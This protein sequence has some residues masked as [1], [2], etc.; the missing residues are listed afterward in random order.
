MIYIKDGQDHV[1]NNSDDLAKMMG[2][3]G[4]PLIMTDESGE[5]ISAGLSVARLI[6]NEPLVKAISDA[7]PSH[8]IGSTPFQKAHI[9]GYTRANGTFV[10]QHEDSR[11]DHEAINALHAAGA[12]H[13]TTGT[14]VI[15]Y[16]TGSKSGTPK[17]L[18]MHHVPNKFDHGSTRH[19]KNSDH[20]NG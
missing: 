20:L 8:I 5:I 16:H 6:A 10:P 3:Q 11:P 7:K 9:A 19:V 18:R 1:I 17:M 13:I 2:H 4:R 14:E 12:K 15:Y